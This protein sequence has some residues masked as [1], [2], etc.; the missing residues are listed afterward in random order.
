MSSLKP[1]ATPSS[2]HPP[3][4]NKGGGGEKLQFPL[5]PGRNKSVQ[6][7]GFTPGSPSLILFTSN[8]TLPATRPQTSP[9]TAQWKT[10]WTDK[11]PENKS[12]HIKNTFAC[13]IFKYDMDCFFFL[14]SILPYGTTFTKQLLEQ[15]TYSFF[16]FFWKD[17]SSKN[18]TCVKA[19]LA[20]L[21]SNLLFNCW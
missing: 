3:H 2:L 19:T 9:L 13:I 7:P 16:C 21:F 14:V 4:N 17:V 5:L 20:T 6:L 12:A 1:C 10:Q 11:S 15:E 8:S 18:N